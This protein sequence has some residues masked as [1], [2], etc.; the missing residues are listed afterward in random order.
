MTTSPLGPTSIAGD[1][2]EFS[3][4]NTLL[5]PVQQ[6]LIVWFPHKPTSSP[7]N[8]LPSST[9][10]QQTPTGSNGDGTNGAGS[11]GQSSVGAGVGAGVAAVVV[12]LG[13][14]VVVV[15]LV[16]VWRMRRKQ[17]KVDLQHENDGGFGNLNNPVYSGKLS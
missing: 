9:V 5:L 6:L 8:V 15:S 2:G 17:S 10:P 12:L 16:I 13:V 1:K 3:V 14:G 7:L 4:Q 11:E